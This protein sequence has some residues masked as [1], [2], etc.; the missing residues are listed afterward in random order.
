MHF[1]QQN[2]KKHE[3]THIE[4]KKMIFFEICL[5]EISYNTPYLKVCIEKKKCLKIFFLREISS[6]A[7]TFGFGISLCKRRFF[8]VVGILLPTFFPTFY[9]P[10]LPHFVHNV[11]W[12]ACDSFGLLAHL[13]NCDHGP[14][15]FA[16]KIDQLH[17]FLEIADWNAIFHFARCVHGFFLLISLSLL[18][19]SSSS[20][21]AIESSGL[22]SSHIS[23]HTVHPFPL[24]YVLFAFCCRLT[25]FNRLIVENAW[26]NCPITFLFRST[27]SLN[28]LSSSVVKSNGLLSF[29]GSLFSNSGSRHSSSPL[30]IRCV[31]IFISQI[32]HHLRAFH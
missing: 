15:F 12:C 11:L 14:I 10:L 30:S 29:A 7:P 32:V 21:S 1:S 8:L 3:K 25:L 23:F 18:I 20:A 4:R 17:Y 5:D 27:A 13:R 31:I 24:G 9:S 26:M 6:A 19:A 2:K 28:F 16:S 22:Y